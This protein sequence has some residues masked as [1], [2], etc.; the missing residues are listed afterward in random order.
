[1]KNFL[2]ILK[3][4]WA[5]TKFGLS[6]ENREELLHILHMYGV[7]HVYVFGSRARGDYKEYSDIDISIKDTLDKNKRA[8]LAIDLRESRVPF[9]VDVVF[10]DEI[11]N[12]TLKNEIDTEGILFQ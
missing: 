11:K 3:T 2:Q 4:F 8:K 6:K 10:Y 7:E 1:M 5:P 12:K 9:T